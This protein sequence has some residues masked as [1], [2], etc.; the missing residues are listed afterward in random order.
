[1]LVRQPSNGKKPQRRC[2]RYLVHVLSLVNEVSPTT[3]C[4]LLSVARFTTA[5]EPRPNPLIDDAQRIEPCSKTGFGTN[6][7]STAICGAQTVNCAA[8]VVAEV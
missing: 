6:R 4:P 2:I 8:L 1:M 7:K 5:I 3:T